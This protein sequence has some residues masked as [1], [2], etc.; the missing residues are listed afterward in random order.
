MSKDPVTEPSD[1]DPPEESVE[2]TIVARMAGV[3]VVHVRRY[4]ELGLLEPKR[5]QPT[6]LAPRARFDPTSAARV[7]RAERLRRDL[8]LNYAG[9]V[10]VVELLDRISELEARLPRS[11]R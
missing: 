4:L 2:L 5:P 7:A 8:S 3:R 10:L 9:A 1:R 11:P 6:A